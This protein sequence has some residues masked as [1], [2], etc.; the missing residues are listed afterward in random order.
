[1]TTQH[2][3]EWAIGIVGVLLLLWLL[4]RHKGSTQTAIAPGGVP[5]SLPNVG[6]VPPDY[7]SYN[8][9][10]AA[11][12][13]LPGVSPISWMS[14]AASGANQGGSSAASSPTCGCAE[15][16]QQEFASIPSLIAY[17]TGQ[18]GNLAANYAANIL[19]AFPSS[20]AAAA[21]TISAGGGSGLG[22]V[23]ILG[24]VPSAGQHF[25]AM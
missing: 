10:A 17:Y 1:M 18:A 3:R 11:K 13:A 5:V 14:P 9:P 6:E 22:P 15:G 12:T 7:L 20:S 4:F 16:N 25:R 8:V 19:S 24:T 23:Q 2:E 21:S